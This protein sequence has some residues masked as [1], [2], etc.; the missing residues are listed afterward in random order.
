MVALDATK[1]A[2]IM[3]ATKLSASATDWASWPLC[4]VYALTACQ[5]L[6]LSCLVLLRV[7]MCGGMRQVT[8]K[9]TD[10]ADDQVLVTGWAPGGLS[11]VRQ[12][13]F[14]YQFLR[15]GIPVSIINFKAAVC[16]AH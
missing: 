7:F 3:V 6:C 15:S 12:P 8:Y 14:Y 9:V 1:P 13:R 10:H 5:Q 2:S 4:G 11:E 16:F